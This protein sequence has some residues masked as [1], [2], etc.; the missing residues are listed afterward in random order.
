MSQSENTRSYPVKKSNDLIQ[1]TMCMLTSQEFDL[2]QYLVMRICDDD[3]EIHEQIIDIKEFCQI[4]GI[5]DA[6]DNYKNIK[7]S[8]QGLANKSVWTELPLNKGREQLCRWIEDPW[9]DKGDGKVCVQLKKYWEPYLLELKKRYTVTT[10][11]ETLPMK[12]VYGKRLYEL[13]NSYLMGNDSSAHIKFSIADLKK[14]LL[15]ESWDKKYKEFKHFHDKVLKPAL[16]DLSDFGH[17]HVSMT[18]RRVGRSYSYVY[19]DVEEK[20]FEKKL[21]SAKKEQAFFEK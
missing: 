14:M 10:L 12:S 1:K 18:L 7:K 4:A 19:F 5:K 8:L 17:L 15:G 16:N 13:L 2:L 20:D 3:T 6:G 11:K 21:S 9:I